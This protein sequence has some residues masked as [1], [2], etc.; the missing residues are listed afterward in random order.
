MSSFGEALIKYILQLY[1]YFIRSRVSL[2]PETLLNIPDAVRA[3]LNKKL[4]KYLEYIYI[5]I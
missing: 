5:Y 2:S 3:H 4:L 1:M